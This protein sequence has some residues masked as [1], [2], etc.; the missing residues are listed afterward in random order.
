MFAKVKDQ[1]NNCFFKGN[2]SAQKILCELEGVTKVKI[3]EAES[4]NAELSARLGT[5]EASLTAA[6]EE[7]WTLQETVGVVKEVQRGAR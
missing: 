7:I 6:C 1:I 3:A 5:V 2:K 4:V